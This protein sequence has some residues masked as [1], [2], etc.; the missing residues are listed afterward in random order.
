MLQHQRQLNVLVTYKQFEVKGRCSYFMIEGLI[1]NTYDDQKW[2]WC[3]I[4]R[5][6]I[7][8]L[9][10]KAQELCYQTSLRRGR[11]FHR[12]QGYEIHYNGV[13]GISIWEQR[14]ILDLETLCNKWTIMWL[15]PSPNTL[16]LNFIWQQLLP[17]CELWCDTKTQSQETFSRKAFA[18]L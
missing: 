4:Y 10:A 5:Q 17:Q 3:I 9:K 12:W 2:N 6:Y 7:D 1:F 11:D 13:I 15:L 16:E 8:G 14:G 18:I